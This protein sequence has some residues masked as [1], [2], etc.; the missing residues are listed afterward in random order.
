M[1]LSAIDLATVADFARSEMRS[2]VKDVHK[3]HDTHIAECW[4]AAL[5]RVVTKTGH[6]LMCLNKEEYL[7]ELEDA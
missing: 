2:R 7:T 4:V 1:K 6:K 5:Q 3:N